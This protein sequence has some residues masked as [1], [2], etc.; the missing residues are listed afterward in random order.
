M[1]N[2]DTTFGCG[3]I[4]D[5]ADIADV[6]LHLSNQTFSRKLDRT[7]QRPDEYLRSNLFCAAGFVLTVHFPEHQQKYLM[8]YETK[9]ANCP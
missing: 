5:S 9:S 4:S 1:I 3:W 2:S 7:E 8:K 6:Q